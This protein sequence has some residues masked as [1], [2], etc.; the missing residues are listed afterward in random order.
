MDMVGDAF[1]VNITSILE[2]LE[3]LNIQEQK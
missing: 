2:K 1:S 3:A